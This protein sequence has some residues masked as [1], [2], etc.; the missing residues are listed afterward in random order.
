LFSLEFPD[1]LAVER[2]KT[3]LAVLTS[4]NDGSHATTLWLAAPDADIVDEPAV[5]AVLLAARKTAGRHRPLSL[6]L[7]GG[8]AASA[9]QAAG[10]RAQQ[11]L[12]WMKIR[13]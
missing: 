1:Q 8:Y 13:F 9:V 5:E 6:N 12:L 10:Y 3:L 7:P 2:D 11:T 4:H